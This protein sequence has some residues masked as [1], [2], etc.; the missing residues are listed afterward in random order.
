[1]T[2][3]MAFFECPF[4]PFATG[5]ISAGYRWRSSSHPLMETTSW[6]WF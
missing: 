3:H 1:M 4:M 6:I 2:P 5:V